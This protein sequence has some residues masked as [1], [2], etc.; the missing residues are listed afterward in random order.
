MQL[1][2]LFENSVTRSYSVPNVMPRPTLETLRVDL[3]NLKR[4]VNTEHDTIGTL[5]QSFAFMDGENSTP[6]PLTNV[7][8]VFA[9]ITKDF[10][11]FLQTCNHIRQSFANCVGRK[12]TMR[13]KQATEKIF[14]IA[15]L[16]TYFKITLKQKEVGT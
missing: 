16:D 1:Y 10:E 7:Q 12:H 15:K 2:V 6:S 4:A 3:K 8:S 13:L 11:A 5:G 9:S 14:G